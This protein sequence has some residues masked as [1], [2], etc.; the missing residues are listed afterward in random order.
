[1]TR[2]KAQSRYFS[3]LPFSCTQVVWIR[4][5]ISPLLTS[6]LQAVYQLVFTSWWMQAIL[7]YLGV[8]SIVEFNTPLRVSLSTLQIKVETSIRTL[9]ATEPV[10]TSDF[11]N[12]CIHKLVKH[13]LDWHLYSTWYTFEV[14]FVFSYF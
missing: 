2:S 1:M 12:T 14:S 7:K 5:L 9:Y 6:I 4:S 13:W 11:K 10:T 8:T 3:L